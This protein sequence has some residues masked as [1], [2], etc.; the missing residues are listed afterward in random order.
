MNPVLY[1][2]LIFLRI[3]SYI[4]KCYMCFYSLVSYEIS[5]MYSQ[6]QPV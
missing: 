1:M 6:A 5:N 2:N 3:A 4:D